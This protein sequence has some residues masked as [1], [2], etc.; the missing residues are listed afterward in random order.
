MPSFGN[1]YYYNSLLRN[2]VIAFGSMFDELTVARFDATGAVVQTIGIP[3]AYGPKE[4]WLVRIKQDPALLKTVQITLPTA[5]FELTGLTYDPTR[6]LSPLTKEIVTSPTDV[7]K[8][9]FVWKGIPWN[10]S[11][12]LYL[13]VKNADDGTQ[14]LEQILPFFS[15]EWTNT[16]ALIPSIGTKIDVPVILNTMTIEDVYEG[17]FIARR[18]IV[19]TLNF[20]MKAAI[21]GPVHTKGVIKEARIRLR[22][23][24]TSALNA[25]LTITPGLTANGTPTTNPAVSIDPSLISA[26]DD[27]GYAVD[28]TE[29]FTGEV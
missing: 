1:A 26:E 2:Y 3:I 25:T 11:F 24:D 28:V 9:K 18:A 29:S 27:Y 5:S 10:L 7:N 4:K 15:P 20:T 19:W 12:S 16:M 23:F 17:D 8:G 22:D 14:L 13:Y 21:Y 6:H